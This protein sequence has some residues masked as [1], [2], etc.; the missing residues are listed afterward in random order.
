MRSIGFEML[1]VGEPHNEAIC[2]TLVVTRVKVFS[3]FNA[4]NSWND[5]LESPH[6]IE[7]CENFI[8]GNLGFWLE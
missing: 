5:L 8:L 6:M 2:I 7:R 1:H 3:C 4:D